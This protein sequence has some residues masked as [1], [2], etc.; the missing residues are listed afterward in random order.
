MGT[1]Q[2]DTPF[3]ETIKSLIEQG[4]DTTLKRKLKS[5]HYA[6]IAEIIE[7]LSIDEAT[8]IIKLLKS[9]TTADALAEVDPDTRERILENLSAKEIAKEVAELDS[10]DATDLILELPE[11]R[12]EK[13]MSQIQDDEHVK[14]I[15]EL[16]KYDENTA[17]SLMAK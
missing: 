13:V 3:L 16:L 5:I 1:F 15:R 4:E 2:I 17:G 12:Q 9:E 11:A 6:D 8:Y 14:D 7:H 10:D